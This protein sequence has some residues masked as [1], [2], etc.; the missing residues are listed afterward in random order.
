MY[1]GNGL[2][3][4]K[5]ITGLDVP[6]YPSAGDAKRDEKI[7]AY[8][9][10][11]DNVEAY[12]AFFRLNVPYIRAVLTYSVKADDWQNAS[13]YIVF[14]DSIAFSNL[15]TGS[16]I[17]TIKNLG[18]NIFAYTPI[19][20]VNWNLGGSSTVKANSVASG[21]TIDAADA[22]HYIKTVSTLPPKLKI[23][24]SMNSSMLAAI[25]NAIAD[26]TNYSF[27]LRGEPPSTYEGRYSFYISVYENGVFIYQYNASQF[28]AF[29][30]VDLRY[31]MHVLKKVLKK[32]L[33]NKPEFSL[34]L[35][36]VEGLTKI[37]SG[38][39]SKC[40]ALCSIALPN[41]IT[42]IENNAFSDCIRLEKVNFAGS[43]KQW[44]NIVVYDETLKKTKITFLRK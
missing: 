12:D 33:K 2:L 10:Y 42:L 6:R 5:E 27:D 9:S 37:S 34:D 4:Y 16:A 23:T 43:K 35:S 15:Q 38:T 3:T 30:Y 21:N 20:L 36:E 17:K 41:S 25:G 8:N 26:R 31:K 7:K 24:G 40:Y 1:S 13:R 44:K 18:S 22:E 19:T 32:A 29:R 14:I 39:F 11:L 28:D